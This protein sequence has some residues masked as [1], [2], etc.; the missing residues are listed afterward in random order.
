MTDGFVTVLKPPGLTSSD[1]V[2]D[3]RRIFG[4]KRVGH[5]GTLDPG[6]SGVLTVC[7]GRAT[8]LFDYI[9][10]KKK[11]YI[12]EIAFGKATDTQ[13]SYGTETA[14][15]DKTVSEEELRAALGCFTGRI[16]QNAPA[17]SAL[18]QNGVK[19]YKLARSGADIET[20]TREITVYACELLTKTSHNRYLLRIEC[21]KGTYIRTICSDIGKSL[22][23][24][25]YM[26][27][28]LR[29]ASGEF[30]LENAFS[31]AELQKMK[32][33]GALEK[34][35]MPMDSAIPHITPLYLSGLSNRSRIRLL[36]GADIA[37]EWETPQGELLRIYIDGAFAGL[38]KR[39]GDRL[40]MT[41]MLGES[42]ENG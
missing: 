29:T 21:S 34:A 18:N 7:L 11:E 4:M 10:D 23:T 12:A 35:V 27:F 17:Y 32:E 28:L 22:G 14:S 30:T 42:A 16:S 40:Q 25:A 19:L 24:C 41:L 3:I 31:I 36:N 6:A 2:T 15:S 38:G 8:R 39:D 26:S 5:G 13:D 20:K 1:V 9:I 33:T 37:C